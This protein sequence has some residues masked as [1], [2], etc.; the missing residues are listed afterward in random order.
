MAGAAK[1]FSEPQQALQPTKMRNGVRILDIDYYAPF[2][3]TAVT[4]AWQRRTSSDYRARFG[5]GIVEWRVLA[6]LN[7]EPDITAHRICEVIRM[8][9]A[10]ASRALSDLSDKGLLIF[11]AE[12]N[13]TRKRRWSLSETGQQMHANIINAAIAHEE[14]LREGVSDAELRMFLKVMH[15][16]LNNL[17]PQPED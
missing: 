11:E 13:D 6:M 4:N 17:D 16:M 12:P 3:L 2:L 14:K 9:K 15:Q 8:D 7:I 1:Q 5:L 10:A